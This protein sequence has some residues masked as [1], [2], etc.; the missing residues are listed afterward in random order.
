MTP[1]FRELVYEWRA[2]APPAPADGPVGAA[3]AGS[4]AGSASGSAAPPPSEPSIA[5]ELQRLFVGLQTSTER[6]IST[7]PL[8]ESFGWDAED[9][10]EQHDVQV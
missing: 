4:R 1:E 5:G 8:T 2:D 3:T 6:A 9:A 7:R 10:F